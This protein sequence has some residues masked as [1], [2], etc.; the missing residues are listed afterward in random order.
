MH[1]SIHIPAVTMMYHDDGSRFYQLKYLCTFGIKSGWVTVLWVVVEYRDW[2]WIFR[3][4]YFIETLKRKR[5]INST[6]DINKESSFS[7]LI[8]ISIEW[9][10]ALVQPHD[11]NYAIAFFHSHKLSALAFI[12]LFT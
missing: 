10:T 2:S 6:V 5:F 9:M 12:D 4:I 3:D 7:I 11:K 8:T 1:F